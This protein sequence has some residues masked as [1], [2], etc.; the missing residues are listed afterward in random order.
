MRLRAPFYDD[1]GK[2]YCQYRTAQR[3]TKAPVIRD[4]FRAVVV[5][6]LKVNIA[7]ARAPY[8]GHAV[9]VLVGA[10]NLRQINIG[11]PASVAYFDNAQDEDFPAIAAGEGFPAVENFA[12]GGVEEFFPASGFRVR[13]LSIETGENTGDDIFLR[14]YALGY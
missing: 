10:D 1:K 12:D 11:E 14:D 4:A 7:A 5:V 8:G 2:G 13:E 3:S 9:A 6:V